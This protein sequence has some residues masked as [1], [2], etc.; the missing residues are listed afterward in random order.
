MFVLFKYFYIFIIL[1]GLS[2]SINIDSLEKSL[3]KSKGEHKLYALYQISS[4]YR[5]SSQSKALA[6]AQQGLQLAEKQNSKPYIASFNAILGAIYIILRQPEK[7]IDY[8]NKAIKI[9]DELKDTASLANYYHNLGIA[10]SEKSDF[11]KSI[12]YYLKA[13]SIYNQRSDWEMISWIHLN[14]APIYYQF[15]NSKK[16]YEHYRITEKMKIQNKDTYGL[17]LLYNNIA[18]LYQKDKDFTKAE[19]YFKKSVN[20]A[21]AQNDSNS[22]A[23][24]KLNL[25]FNCALQENHKKAISYYREALPI[26][27]KSN[28]AFLFSSLYNYI[29]YSYY[30]TG[31]FDSAFKYIYR[32]LEISKSNNLNENL[33]NSYNTLH[34][35]YNKQGDF[36]SAYKYLKQEFELS[37]KINK[38]KFNSE[39][40]QK[41]SQFTSEFE[42]KYELYKMNQELEEFKQTEKLNKLVII[43]LSLF[44]LA[45]VVIIIGSY[46]FF[47]ALRKTNQNLSD[48]IVE[49]KEKDLELRN[50][51]SMRDKFFGIIAHDLKGPLGIY[52]N[53]SAYITKHYKE[54]SDLE[55]RQFMDDILISTTNIN[56]L[57]DNLL[58]WSR[59]HTG[60]QKPNPTDIR[61]DFLIHKV[62][63]DINQLSTEKNI[64]I[65]S[66]IESDIV[67]F[68]DFT[69]IY[70]VI[71]NLLS[72]AV[73]YSYT[74]SEID[75]SLR[76]NHSTVEFAISDYGVGIPEER[77]KDIFTYTR[78]KTYGTNS[79]PGTGLGLVLSYELS[80]LHDAV[81][82]FESQE[83]KGSTFVLQIP[84]NNKNDK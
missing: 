52:M 63:E 42:S 80:R 14:M 55:I 82:S 74:N 18:N 1:S 53:I 79:E 49:L 58:L 81:I 33:I 70:T 30:K 34:Q 56:E 36:E 25:G 76:K 65:N 60:K 32:S 47:K 84:Y 68:A 38:D 48:A 11:G 7:G 31:D 19:H 21:M 45:L 2:Y 12:E 75:I 22:F 20:L 59:I 77:Q 57:L 40:A 72:N 39:L 54:M 35:I 61:L 43:F 8:F 69:M 28:V 64:K 78:Y 17:M 71:K 9:A 6:M 44:L 62:I 46:F 41:T 23:T 3:P 15:G 50:N 13:L 83:N 66:D 26:I 10:Y 4:H 37:E 51:I 29:G 16:A 5:N 67:I 73:K 27:A 24:G